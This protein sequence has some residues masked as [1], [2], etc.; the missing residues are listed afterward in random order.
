MMSYTLLRSDSARPVVL[1]CDHA[2]HTVP[3]ELENLGLSD[4]QIRQHIGWDIGA[5]DVTAHI[6]ESLDISAVLS[7]YSRLYIDCN[8]APSSSGSIPEKSDNIIIPNNHNLSVGDKIG[9]AELSLWP[10]HQALSAALARRWQ[11]CVAPVLVS[12]H[13]FTPAL[14]GGDLR[15][16]HFGLISG[17]DRRLADRVIDQFRHYTEICLGDNEPYSGFDISYTLNSHGL[18]SGIAHLGIEIRQDL[19]NTPEGVAYYGAILAD[20]LKRALDDVSLYQEQY[21]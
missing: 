15:P 13:S 5:A 12:I 1:C 3:K 21:F 11:G 7:M 16:W 14:Q 10:Y 4:A 20:V 18:S 8:R 17:H 2:G 9:R 6:A 19:I